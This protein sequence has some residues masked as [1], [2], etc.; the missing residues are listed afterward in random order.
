MNKKNLINWIGLL[1]IVSF[2]SYTAAVLFAPLA[3]PDYNWLSQ[4]VSDLSAVN[5]PSL[6][7]WNQLA[8]FY[9]IC[10]IV[11]IMTVCIAVQ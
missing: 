11:S 8:S 10:G 9:E 4:A 6:M 1:G 2:L 5:S 3:Y 7:L